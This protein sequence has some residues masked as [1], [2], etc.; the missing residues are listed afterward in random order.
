MICFHYCLQV[1]SM[2]SLQ[3]EQLNLIEKYAN[4]HNSSLEEQV[5]CPHPLNTRKKKEQE[6]IPFLSGFS[7]ARYNHKALFTLNHNNSNKITSKYNAQWNY[8]LENTFCCI[9]YYFNIFAYHNTTET[10][11]DSCN[12]NITSKSITEL[13]VFV[14]RLQVDSLSLPFSYYYCFYYWVVY[15]FIVEKKTFF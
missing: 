3:T 2:L 8:F 12:Q 9:Y 10:N 14:T 6:N 5:F 15:H 1:Q 11:I 13:V 4:T 7:V